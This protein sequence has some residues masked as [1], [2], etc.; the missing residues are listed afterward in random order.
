M[1]RHEQGGIILTQAIRSA[2]GRYV[3]AN[4]LR[5]YYEECGAGEPLILIHGGTGVCQMW[6]PHVR[7]FAERYRVVTPDSRG[8]GHTANPTGQF[9]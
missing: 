4:G 5:I 3:D 1:H 2:S 7:F 6:Q 8:H 9:S